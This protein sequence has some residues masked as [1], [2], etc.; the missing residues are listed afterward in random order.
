MMKKVTSMAIL[1]ALIVGCQ[2]PVPRP[3]SD[4]D[5][6]TLFDKSLSYT[7]YP[8]HTD[9]A[10]MILHELLPGQQGTNRAKVLNMMGVSFDIQGVYDS[11]AYYLYEASRIAEEVRD[12]S[13]QISVYSNLGM[14]Q[15][16]LK[17]AEESVAYYQKALA[18]AEKSNHS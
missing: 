11:A 4:E 15:Y 5:F 9:S 16:T 13:L 14:L 1:F 8:Y 6:N 3:A 18:I 7:K 12:D 17:N 2:T 10:L